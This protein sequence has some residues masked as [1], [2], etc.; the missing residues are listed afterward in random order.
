MR[1]KNILADV[2]ENIEEIIAQK[3]AVGQSLWHTFLQIHP[4][5]IA[6]FLSTIPKQLAQQLFAKLPNEIKM[7]VFEDFSDLMQGSMLESMSAQEK[8]EAFQ[9]L[10]SDELAD[11]FDHLSD[12]ELKQY[13]N[14]LGK[15]IREKVLSLLQFEPDSAGGIMTTD[16]FTLTHDFTVDQA[17]K[18][19]QRVQPNRDIHQHIF[20]VDK[21]YNLLGHINLEDLVLQKPDTHI[22]NFMQ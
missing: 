15:D 17:I 6:N 9:S 18:L 3:S 8:V 5:D 19:L 1:I 13:L 16:V 7:A 4:A 20:V 22:A 2:R 10:P 12:Q 14:L 11:L 21:K